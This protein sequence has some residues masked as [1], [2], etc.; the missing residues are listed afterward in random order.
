MWPTLKHMPKADTGAD[1]Y[2]NNR[3][4]RNTALGRA[5]IGHSGAWVESHMVLLVLLE[6]T[7]CTVGVYMNGLDLKALL[8]KV[9]RQSK[10][11][12]AP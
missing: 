7:D 1:L 5:D 3:T 2:S 10:A 9:S 6:C 11:K 4:S 8:R 12:Q